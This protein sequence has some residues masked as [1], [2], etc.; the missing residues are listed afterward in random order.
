M[1]ADG[2]KFAQTK[3]SRLIKAIKK[4]TVIFIP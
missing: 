4:T 2:K 3:L 1:I